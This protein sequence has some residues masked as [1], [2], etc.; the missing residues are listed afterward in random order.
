MAASLVLVTL[1]DISFT[2]GQGIGMSVEEQWFMDSLY[3]SSYIVMAGALYWYY[4]VM[5]YRGSEN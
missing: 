2:Y 3:A 5:S 4:R 1:A